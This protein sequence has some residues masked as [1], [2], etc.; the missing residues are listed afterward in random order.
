MGGEHCVLSIGL[1]VV[2][3]G[4]CIARPTRAVLL[5]LFSLSVCERGVVLAEWI[6]GT[7]SRPLKSFF[8]FFSRPTKAVDSPELGGYLRVR[9]CARV[10]G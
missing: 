3:A 6:I 1:S 7:D 2:I 8:R 9:V 5:V 4:T 10:A